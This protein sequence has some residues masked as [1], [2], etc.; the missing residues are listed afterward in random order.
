[1]GVEADPGDVEEEPAPDFPRV[2]PAVAAAEREGDGA[3]GLSR[4]PE[5]VRQPV[6]RAR[7]RPR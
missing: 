4:D 7:F 1:V 5:R 3:I 6:A 2:D